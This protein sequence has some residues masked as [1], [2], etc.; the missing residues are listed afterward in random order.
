ETSTDAAFR[1]PATARAVS[2]GAD[3][4]RPHA[5][6]QETSGGSGA[7]AGAGDHGRRWRSRCRFPAILEAQHTGGGPAGCIRH[8]RADPEARPIGEMASA[9][10]LPRRPGLDRPAR[11]AGGPAHDPA[12]HARRGPGARARRVLAEEPA[13]DGALGTRAAAAAVSAYSP[14]S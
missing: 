11:S 1:L 2:A 14:M 13:D 8:P 10:R 6:E 5:L 9:R 12:D 3:S 4:L 7:R